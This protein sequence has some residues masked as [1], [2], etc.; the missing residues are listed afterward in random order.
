MQYWSSDFPVTSD[1]I[2]F[3]AHPY[4]ASEYR[5]RQDE[6]LIPLT[7]IPPTI[8][9][10]VMRDADLVVSVAQLGDKGFTSREIVKSRIELIQALIEDLNLEGVSFREQFAYVQGKLA[11]YRVHMGSAVIHIEPGSY[12]CVVPDGWGKDHKNLFLP[13]SD[14][15]DTKT[16]E[17]ISKIFLLLNDDKIKDQSILRQI[18]RRPG[19]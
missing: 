11:K 1:Q 10:E 5:D 9:S 15:G 12:L 7:E 6:A 3:R 4:R 19:E 17:V 16:S 13:F 14:A 8:F 2:K 18:N